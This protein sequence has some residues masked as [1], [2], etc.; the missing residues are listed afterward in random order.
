MM[1]KHALKVAQA[2]VTIALLALLFRGLDIQALR[3]LFASLSLTTYLASLVV[4]LGGQVLYAWRWHVVMAAAGA[5]VTTWAAVR[6]YFIGTFLNNFFPSTV[7]GDLSKVYYF[8]RT[9][10]YRRI[11][12]SIFLDRLLGIG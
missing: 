3:A 9:F 6:Q 8:G 7:G 4:V 10:G 11:T 12:A 2:V 1:R 5:E